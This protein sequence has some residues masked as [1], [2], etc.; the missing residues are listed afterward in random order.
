M[1]ERRQSATLDSLMRSILLTA[2]ALGATVTTAAEPRPFSADDVFELEWARSP[3]ISPALYGEVVWVR[4]GYDRRSD[5]PRGALWADRWRRALPTFGDRARGIPS[6]AFSPDGTP[7]YLASEDG[8][9]RLRM[10]WLASAGGRSSR[11]R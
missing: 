4:T 7:A 1:L 6:P 9:T 11:P 10:R 5:R 8:K 2:L 3:V